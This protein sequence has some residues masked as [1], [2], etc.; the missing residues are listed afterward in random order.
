MANVN[1]PFGLAP[2]RKVDGSPYNGMLKKV[3]CDV[4]K[5]YAIFK[6]DPIT[7]ET[8]GYVIASASTDEILG[9][10]QY[11]E[12]LVDSKWVVG[13]IFLLQLLDMF[14]MFLLKI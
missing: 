6:G 2:V 14:I 9:V 12:Y 8:D 13:I 5:T 7:L 1:K 4:S 3:E 11:F 10:A